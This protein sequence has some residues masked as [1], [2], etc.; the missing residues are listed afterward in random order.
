LVGAI[1]VESAGE[2][3]AAETESSFREQLVAINRTTKT[4]RLIHAR[5][6]KNVPNPRR[7]SPE[8]A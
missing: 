6:P 8:T 1:Y 2:G 3:G 5:N 7:T 4:I